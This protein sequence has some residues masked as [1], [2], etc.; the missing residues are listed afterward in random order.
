MSQLAE[1]RRQVRGVLGE[2]AQLESAFGVQ[3][4]AL[5]FDVS[6]PV[7]FNVDGEIVARH[8]GPVLRIGTPQKAQVGDVRHR[9]VV[10]MQRGVVRRLQRG[11]FVSVSADGVVGGV[12]AQMRLVLPRQN[13]AG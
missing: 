7:R 13:A 2:D 8:G 10:E 1:F 9:A 6:Q 4:F 3:R 12:V 11:D 5:V